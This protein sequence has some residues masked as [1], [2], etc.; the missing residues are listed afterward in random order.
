MVGFF[1][2]EDGFKKRGF[3]RFAGHADGLTPLQVSPRRRLDDAVKT[4]SNLPFG[5]TDCALPMRYA[6][7]RRREIDD[8]RDLHRHGDLGG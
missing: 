7:A 1:A 6:Q 3:G 5:G 4:I 8:V 2:G